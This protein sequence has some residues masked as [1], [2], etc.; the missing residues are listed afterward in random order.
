VADT[1]AP[2]RLLIVNCASPYFFYIPMGSFGLCDFLG[3]QGLEARIFSP[4]LY[5]EAAVRDRFHATLDDFQPTH[6]GLVCHWQETAHGLISALAMVK[7]WNPAVVAFSGGFTASYFAESLLE[8]L[9]QLDYV[10]IGD[11]EETVAQLLLGRPPAEMANL[12]WRQDGRIRRSER[13]WLMEQ[14][15]FDALRFA[16]LSPLIDANRYIDKINAKLGFPLLIGRGCVFDCAYCGGSR[17]AFRLH[18]GR[19]KPVARSI[20]AMLADLRLLKPWTTILYL[21]YE[22]DF[23]LIKALFRAIADDPELCGHFTL[24]YGAWRLLDAEFLEL[25]RRA[26]NCAA[27]RPIIE[28]SPET[29]SD[30]FRATIKRGSTYS[31]QQMEE[32]FREISEAFLGRVRIEVFF[33][34]YHP[35]VPAEAL[36]PELGAVLRLKHAMALQGLPVHICFDHLSTD[37][38]SRYWED[39]NEHPHDFARFLALKAQVDQ[40]SLHPFPVDNLC[41]RIPD[42]LDPALLIRFEALA[43]TLEMLE[44]HCRE[45]VHV[46]L[47]C[48]D[49]QWLGPLQA[50]LAPLLE[51]RVNAFFAEPPLDAVIDELGRRLLTDSAAPPFLPDL[52]RFSRKKLEQGAQPLA[53]RPA[54]PQPADCFALNLARLSIHEHNYLDLPPLLH[55]LREHPITLP[56]Q[57]TAFLFLTAGILTL[58][59]AVYRRTLQAFER[60]LSLTTYRASLDDLDARRQEP[61]LDRL[62]M[63]G[64]LLP[65]PCPEPTP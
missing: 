10:V 53:A 57:R 14:P 7:A 41:L 6:V 58:P 3:Q 61:L 52:L 51:S 46:L 26:F 33:S 36:E 2:P 16:D 15:L 8:H 54:S 55:K 56:Y 17:R 35:A 20:A 22:N 38:G 40:G 45:L 34:R 49:D 50:V 62:I 23:A 19:C 31:L 24:H 48:L 21:C 64:V 11:P 27:E 44:R 13:V 60:P 25:Y 29:G 12:A 4:S 9:E 63:E 1:S 43:L 30:Q 18:S 28:F 65:V 37:V 5:P 42:H 59:H 39:D 32:N 47:A